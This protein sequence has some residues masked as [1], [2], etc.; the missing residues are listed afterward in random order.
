MIAANA[1]DCTLNGAVSP[2]LRPKRAAGR[3]GSR[4]ASFGG[5]T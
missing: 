1:A 5:G 2:R 3:R 4:M